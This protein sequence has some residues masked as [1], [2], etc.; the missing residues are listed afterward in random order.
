VE[1]E[2]LNSAPSDEAGN[3]DGKSGGECSFPLFSL[4]AQR[5]NGVINS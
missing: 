5:E 1:W 4:L 2:H 3:Q